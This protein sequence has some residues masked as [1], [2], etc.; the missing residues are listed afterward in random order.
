MNLKGHA[1][2]LIRTPFYWGHLS[3]AVCA[4]EPA[5]HHSPGHESGRSAC[6]HAHPSRRR[7]CRLHGSRGC[8]SRW[9][10]VSY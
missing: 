8:A 1:G 7:P 10:S 6:N 9:R 4:G 2:V 5:D 3:G